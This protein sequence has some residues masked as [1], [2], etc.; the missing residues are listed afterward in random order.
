MRGLTRVVHKGRDGSIFL[1]PREPLAEDC[2]ADAFGANEEHD[3]ARPSRHDTTRSVAGWL[4]AAAR[5]LRHNLPDALPA[6]AKAEAVAYARLLE[7]CCALRRAFVLRLRDPSGESWVGGPDSRVGS[8]VPPVPPPAPALPSAPP[9]PSACSPFEA[10]AQRLA[11]A[12]QVIV[13]LGAGAS[14]SAG[15][16]DFRSPGTGLYSQLESYGLPF[17]EAV[18]DL[19]FFADNPRPFYRLAKELWPGNH[20]PTPA[21]H[22]ISL[23]AARG[24]LRR[25]YTQNIDSL[26]SAAGVPPELTV[27]AHGNFDAAHAWSASRPGGSLRRRQAVGV[28]RLREALWQ[29]EEAVEALNEESGGLVKPDIVFFGEQLPERFGRL[30]PADFDACDLLLVMGTSLQVQPFASLVDMP[31]RDVPRLL[32]NRELVGSFDI[33]DAGGAGPTGADPLERLLSPPRA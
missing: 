21:H 26:E 24:I 4:S 2:G 9:A 12:R 5:D 30:V 16:P 18:F 32:I 22:F 28:E 29:G 25:C 10:F 31:A 23:L 14:V 15:I 13:M 7:D 8:A 3:V 11:R 20:A 33:A 19:T 6:A 1:I 17:P 27:A